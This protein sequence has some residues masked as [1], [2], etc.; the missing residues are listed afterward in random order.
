MDMEMMKKSW[1]NLSAAEMSDIVKAAMEEL[2][3]KLRCERNWSGD[4][5]VTG[6]IIDGSPNIMIIDASDASN[7]VGE[8]FAGFF[9]L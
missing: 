1:E 2:S 4:I 7:S 5:A 8:C 9:R 3:D 6:N